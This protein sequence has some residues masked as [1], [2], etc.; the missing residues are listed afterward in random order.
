MANRY[1]TTRNPLSRRALSLAL[2]LITACAPALAGAAAPTIPGFYGKVPMPG[3][4]VSGTLPVVLPGRTPVGATLGAVGNTLTVN[5]TQAQATIDWEKFNM[6]P[7]SVVIFNQKE[8]GVPQPQWVALNRIHDAKPSLIFGK[9]Q[10]DGKVYLINRNGILFGPGSQVNVHSLVASNLNL[11][12]ANFQNGKLR[13]TTA[14]AAGQ[15]AL[16]NDAY[17]SNYGTI[18]TDSG[19][20]VFLLGPNVVNAGT[21]SS[22]SG[23]INLIGVKGEGEVE[24]WE[25]TADAT[26]NDVIYSDLQAAG[27]VYNAETGG[28]VTEAGGRIGMYGATVQ[29]DGLIRSVTALKKGGVVYLSARDKVTTG[30][31]SVIETPID[32]SNETATPSL[33]YNSGVITLGGLYTETGKENDLLNSLNLVEY[34][35]AIVAPSGLV[36]MTARDSIL[37]G[38]TSS[39][40]VSGLWLDRVASANLIDVQLNSV[41]LRDFYGQKSGILLG[42]KAK[43]DL[44]TGSNIGDLSTYYLGVEK[45]AQQRSTEGGSILFGDTKLA[46]FGVALGELVMEKGAMLDFSGGGTRY[47]AGVMAT[48]RLVSGNKIYDMASAPQWVQYDRLADSQ[49]RTHQRFGVTEKFSGLYFGGG[50]S[51]QDLTAARTVGSDAGSVTFKARVMALDG[52]LTGKATTGAYQT[53]VHDRSTD[54]DAYLISAARGLET[55]DGGTVVIGEAY[56]ADISSLAQHKQDAI[57]ESIVLTASGVGDGLDPGSST[58]SA[59]MLKL[60]GLSHLELYANTT[61]K[62][63]DDAEISLLPGGTLTARGRRIEH[64]GAIDVAGG[65]VEMTTRPNVSSH[66]IIDQNTNPLYREV[67][68]LVYLGQGSRISVAGERVDNSAPG[69]ALHGKL[70]T[71]H[72]AGGS[73]SI[74]ERSE[75]GTYDRLGSTDE[76]RSLVLASGALLDVSG[77]W[78]IDGKGKISGASAG[79]L[80]L[81]GSTLSLA[82][83]MRGHSLPGAVGGEIRLHAGEVLVTSHDLVLPD[84]RPVDGTVP[85]YLRGRLVLDEDRLK[86]T[87]FSRIAL[88]AV[89]DITFSDGAVLAPSLA[90]GELPVPLLVSQSNGTGNA[91]VPDLSNGAIG[92]YLGAT[93]V[94]LVAG[95]NIYTGP[96]TLGTTEPAESNPFARV[97]LESGTAVKAAPGGNVSITAPGV[98]IAGIL[99]AAGGTVYME[100]TGQELILK[101]GGEIRAAGYNKDLTSTVAG[102]PAGYDPKGGGT[103][104]LVSSSSIGGI[105][106]E[107]GSLVDVSGSAPTQRLV[108][109]ADGVPVPVTVAGDPGQLN[110]T[111]MNSLSMEGDISGE[112]R[113]EGVRGATLQV[114]KSAGELRIGEGEVERFVDS[115]FDALT[116]VISSSLNKPG[117]I[118]LPAQLDVSIG[119][120]L[121]LDAA[122]I[123][124]VDGGQVN[125]SAPSIT[126]TNTSI[127]PAMAPGSPDAGTGSIT[128]AGGF[129]EVKGSTLMSGFRDVT[130]Q[131]DHDISFA[132]RIYGTGTDPA[133]KGALGVT[134][135]LTLE[136]ARVYPAGMSDFTVASKGKVTILPGQNPDNGAVYSAGGKLTIEAVGGI[137]HAGNLAA[138]M[139]SITLR[140]EEGRVYLTQES[141][142]STAGTGALPYGSYDGTTWSAR[143]LSDSLKGPE[144]TDAP[145]NSITLSGREVVVREGATQDVSGGGSIYATLFQRGIPG[146]VDPRTKGERFVILPGNDVKLAGAAVYLDAAPEFELAAG[147]YTVLSGENAKA[148]AHLPGALVVEKTKLNLPAGEK[149]LS[150]EGYLV[151]AGYDTVA[152]T[153]IG[154]SLR[155]GYLIRNAMEVLNEGDITVKDFKAK[156]GG[157]FTLR[158]TGGAS[159]AGTLADRPLTGFSG[160]VLSLSARD[161]LIREGSEGLDAGVD[162]ATA[163][164]NE[165]LQLAAAGFNEGGYRE[166]RLGDQGITETV[167]VQSGVELEAP[168]LTL[169]AKDAVTVE[170]GAKVLATGGAD[171]GIASVATSSGTFTLDGVLHATNGLRL[172]VADAVIN[173]EMAADKSSMSLTADKIIF[174]ENGATQ[175]PGALYLTDD[176]DGKWGWL[177]LYSDLT[178][179]SRSDMEFLHD[180][181]LV[182]SGSLTLDAAGYVGSAGADVSLAAT[183]RLTLLNS[184]ATSPRTALSGDATASLTLSGAEIVVAPRLSGS[185]G[186]VAFDKFGTVAL[187]SDGDLTLKGAGAIR[188]GGNLALTAARVTTSYY[189]HDADPAKAGDTAIPYTAAGIRLDAGSGHVSIV[190]NGNEAGNSRTPGGSLEIAGGSIT[191]GD[192]NVDPQ[193]RKATVVEVASGQLKL[194]ATGDIVVTDRTSLLAGGTATELPMQDA[195]Y[196]YTPAGLISLKSGTGKIDL[197]LGSTLDVSAA[198][199]GDAGTVAL[200]ATA[201]SVILSGTITGKASDGNGGSFTIDSAALSNST[202]LDALSK[203]LSDGGFDERIDLRSRAGNL[204]LSSGKTISGREVVIAADGGALD[205]AGNI[206]ADGAKEGEAGGRIELYA[207]TSLTLAK[208]ATISAKGGAGADGGD[209]SLSSL[210][211]GKVAGNYALAVDPDAFIDVSGGSEGAGGTV[212]MRAYRIGGNDVNMAALASKSVV[213]ASMVSV[214][215]A[216]RYDNVTTVG[217]LKQYLDDA[218]TF[219]ENSDTV[220]NRDTMKTRLF[221]SADSANR[222]QAGIEIV[223]ADGANLALDTAWDL[224][225]LRPGG[226]AGVLTLRSGNDLTISANLVDRGTHGGANGY[227]TLHSTDLRESWGVNLVAGAA[228]AGGANY[229]GAEAAKGNMTFG[230]NGVVY[231]EYAPI[232]FAAGNDVIVNAPAAAAGY[233]INKAM[234]Y[235]L[236]GY[237]GEIRGQVGNSLK[238]NASGAAIQT[239]LGDIDIRIGRDLELGANAITSGAIR[240]TGEYRKYGADGKPLQVESMPGRGDSVTTGVS[241]YWTYQ[242]GGSIVLDVVGSVNG[243]LSKENGWDGVFVDPSVTGTTKALYPRYLTA[244]FGDGKAGGENTDNRVTVGLATMGGGDLSVR[245]GGSLLTQVG[246]FG[247]GDLEVVSGSDLIGRFRTMDGAMTLV[248]GGGFGKDDTANPTYRSVLELARAQADVAAQ[249][250]VHLGAILNPDNNRVG[251]FVTNNALKWNMTYTPDASAR[252]ASL[253]GDATLYGTVGY[254]DTGYEAVRSRILPATLS[255]AAAGDLNIRQ[256]FFLAPSE[257]GNLSLFAG[258]DVSGD[259]SGSGRNTANSFTMIDV[260]AIGDFYGRQSDIGTVE[261]LYKVPGDSQNAHSQINHRNDKVPVTVAAGDDIDTIRLVLNKQAHIFAADDIRRLDL[262]GQNNSADSVTMVSAGGSIDQGITGITAAKTTLSG[263]L[264]YGTAYPEIVIGGPG[265]L[266][267][268]ARDSINLGDSRGIQSIGNLMNRAFTGDQTDSDIIVSVGAKT[269]LTPGEARKVADALFTPSTPGGAGLLDEK[270]ESYTKLKADGKDD[271]AQQQLDAAR[272]EI[273]K[274]FDAPAEGDTDGSLSMIDSEISSGKADIS[275]MARNDL[276]V[277]RTALQDPNKPQANTGINTTFG[278]GINIYSGDDI[279]VNESRVMTF[280]GGNM[281][282]WS[283]LGDINAGR[284]SKTT[285]SSSGDNDYKYDENGNIVSIIL[286][287]PAVGS[288]LRALTYDPDGSSGPLNAP[289]PGDIHAYAPNGTI[290]AGEAGIAGGNVVLGAD[291]IDNSYGTISATAGLLA[292]ASESSISLGALTGNSSLSDSAKTADQVSSLGTGKEKT[293]KEKSAVEEFFSKWLDLKIISFEE[294]AVQEADDEENKKQQKKK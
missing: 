46:E 53:G 124:G 164:P 185:K 232:S 36:T 236:G 14:P 256:V 23:K 166:L 70:G 118:L 238:L 110:L 249:G 143:D 194:S 139:G 154:S 27:A 54:E 65:S 126:L 283:D 151:V 156:N 48:S 285:V 241:S 29:H 212:S 254:T 227:L 116:F 17:V 273:G 119:R 127:I 26:A 168:S 155:N 180:V 148:Y 92:D 246:T 40:D 117:A 234:K 60:A 278:G 44:L 102:F 195:V 77:G 125:I 248:S 135:N 199:K 190:G 122:R 178:L 144:V 210:A 251:V 5:Q 33:L 281:V 253:A 129:V 181:N 80:E 233:M 130:L 216:R 72:T 99:E 38:A 280:M 138:P 226:E 244:G 39:I 50:S 111:Y 243:N 11:T 62:I 211:S 163:L 98:E 32:A 188:T 10:A 259:P 96:V 142:I 30:V 267:V 81:K 21:V 203:T 169:S 225:A 55:P 209:V 131:A 237:G 294:P 101:S 262:I 94:S 15:G 176:P 277:G 152:D 223:S 220:K 173:G 189:S 165:T 264:G 79:T 109:G 120:S 208:D 2:V 106:L 171:S 112:G 74:Q 150:Q 289:E 35:G 115:G 177:G 123:E 89:N 42:Q 252:V 175:L 121:T 167:T 43:V 59:E 179:A 100:A 260:D 213:G 66:E 73:I 291:T 24:T 202:G 159:Y 286:K 9:I 284:G 288:G 250:D 161:I 192:T 68:E 282:I 174:A 132:D 224:S 201:G 206:K 25:I 47:S 137:E 270:G 41:Y 269:L 140:S 34:R 247:T 86:D 114:V 266:L 128:L 78:S 7:D 184:G 274:Y 235:N 1:R 214:E 160:G 64:Y 85:E 240:T 52:T 12:D 290:F 57:T 218:D 275:I 108:A 58:I 265:T 207:G 279:N 258:G 271:E 61:L 145:A 170:G 217:A 219:L 245:S 255:L 222:L 263:T 63:A 16:S 231:T 67:T 158:A 228:D 153:S 18:E 292:P 51:V 3:A 84:N 157:D 287:V 162:F 103:V 13:F 191:V 56:G 71:G 268:Q 31:A 83:E 91:V 8:E 141:R 193:K 242:N 146:S 182:A 239:A 149:A 196:S 261:A 105:R 22:P 197:A 272:A 97:V 204:A 107:A 75:Y 93:S 133:L 134:G 293:L 69:L 183:T 136:A 229:K 276:N 37:L 90:K 82:G 4:P 6:A 87:G 187:K 49:E 45:D 200:S 113:L 76:G 215:A 257:T 95:Q 88:S 172:D 147:V 104:S 20:S 19:G 198:A 230:P 205:I 221:G 186:N 28:L